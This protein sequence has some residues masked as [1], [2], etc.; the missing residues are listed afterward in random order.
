MSVCGLLVPNRLLKEMRTER[1]L[2]LPNETGGFLVGKRRGEFIEVTDISTQGPDDCATPWSF[3]R[4]DAKHAREISGAWKSSAGSVGLVGDWHSHPFG[5]GSPSKQD[6][7]AWKAIVTA[8][9][10]DCVGLIFGDAE[11][12]FLAERRLVGI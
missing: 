5:D 11:R 10:S 8:T 3:D 2:A 6:R 1:S 4:S 7:G 9:R 12:A